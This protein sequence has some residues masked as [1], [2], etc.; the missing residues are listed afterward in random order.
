VGL[1]GARR[2]SLR[3]SPVVGW[4]GYSRTCANSGWSI[5]LVNASSSEEVIDQIERIAL[6]D[7]RREWRIS[8]SL[9][10]QTSV[11]GVAIA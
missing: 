1:G 10:L 3:M 2:L 11:K 6:V 8:P 9:P 4:S 7:T 5:G